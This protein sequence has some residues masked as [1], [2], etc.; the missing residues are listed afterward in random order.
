MSEIAP[1]GGPKVDLAA[2]TRFRESAELRSQIAAKTNIVVDGWWG[3][4]T[5]R[6]LQRLLYWVE[7]TSGTVWS[8][9][10][11]YKKPNPGLAQGW[12]WV[13]GAGGCYLIHELQWWI[14]MAPNNLDGLIGPKT[15]RALQAYLGRTQD[16][17]LS[18][19]SG[20]I[21]EMQRRLNNGTF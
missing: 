17:V 4:A 21:K 20:T 16:G 18:G 8:Q 2:R 6:A 7:D 14:G 11:V 12:E 13:K 5:T 15:I 1:D 19:P 3:S 10:V 9:N